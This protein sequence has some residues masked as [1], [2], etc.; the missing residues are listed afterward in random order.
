[1]AVVEAPRRVANANYRPIEEL[2]TH[3]HGAGKRTAQVAAEILIAVL[4]QTTGKAVG[5]IIV[6]IVIHP[7]S[8]VSTAQHDAIAWGGRDIAPLSG[9]QMVPTELTGSMSPQASSRASMR[10]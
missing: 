10:A 2:T 4:S 5:P 6:T 1:M 8:V 7:E 3:A 9:K